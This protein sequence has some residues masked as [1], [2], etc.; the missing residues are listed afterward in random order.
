[1]PLHDITPDTLRYCLDI[2]GDD[3]VVMLFWDATDPGQVSSRE[4]IDHCLRHTDDELTVLAID[5]S[6]HPEA[7]DEWGIAATPAFHFRRDQAM[8]REWYGPVSDDELSTLVEQ[9]F[10]GMARRLVRKRKTSERAA[11]A[12][13]RH[14]AEEKWR[15]GSGSR[16]VL[17]TP[18]QLRDH[19]DR[20]IRGQTRAKRD[21]CTAIYNHYLSQADR[22]SNGGEPRPHHI[23]LLG[24]TG[25]GKTLIVRT[26]AAML[27]VPFVISSA[28][29]LVEAGFRGRSPD[30]MVKSLLDKAQG[31]ARLAEKGIIFI[32]EIDK[33]RRQDCGGS[34]DVSGEGVQ[35][36]L[37]TIIGG[38]I[39]DNVDGHSHAPVDTS[40]ILFVCTG[41]FVDLP[42]IVRRR[43]GTRRTH[44]G[45]IGR[46]GESV[47]DIPDPSIYEA[48]CQAQTADLV[49]F[50]LIPEFI[51]RFT[52][53]SALHELGRD[54][55]RRIIEDGTEESALVHH[56]RLAAI[57]GID[58]VFDDGALDAI[59]AEAME[60]GTGA[61][62]LAR[63]ITRVM[64]GV[65][66]TW[67][68]FAEEGVTKV[69]IDKDVVLLGK[70]PACHKEPPTIRRRDVELRHTFL[71]KVPVRPRSGVPGAEHA[72]DVLEGMSD[73]DILASIDR[74][75][76]ESLGWADASGS[77]RVW[78]DAI[79]QGTDATSAHRIA[80][81]LRNRGATISQAF[82]AH[83]K[84]GTDDVDA[85][86]HYLDYLLAK[87]KAKDRAKRR[88][89]P[90][91][92]DGGSD[93]RD[94]LPF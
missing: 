16:T 1:M 78:W 31:D 18:R 83:V 82:S 3:P 89:R 92:S 5:V 34:R 73:R 58:L 62:G 71:E 79:Q 70:E 49:E 77:E 68:E 44:I 14:R 76:H 69:V 39:A 59:A 32:D 21:V 11:R 38:K 17:P 26:L 86:I 67:P 43:L 45:F 74:I 41:A 55:L 46:S 23:L 94:D 4:T 54:D 40:K 22:E 53:V 64:D 2:A 61:R 57:H 24:P 12:V 51:G 66:R 47:A 81:K 35:N 27:G 60:L 75:K 7:A 29:G 52:T 28:A 80:E 10:P 36:A 90:S 37:L 50:G 56:R 48:L 85:V 84:A 63:L 25:C 65:D 13:V 20:F 93:L 33:I 8:V 91:R 19:L 30:A 9:A 6:R 42:R 72:C 15:Q 88:K 87:E